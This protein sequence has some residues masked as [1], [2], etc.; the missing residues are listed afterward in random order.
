[1]M[2]LLLLLLVFGT[3]QPHLVGVPTKS[4]TVFV[5]KSPAMFR[6]ALF[7]QLITQ[8]ATSSAGQ[9]VEQVESVDCEVHW[10]Q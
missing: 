10:L 5:T 3:L 1:M 4:G 6:W 7:M 2:P 8:S 9:A